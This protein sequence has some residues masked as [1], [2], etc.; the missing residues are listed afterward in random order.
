MWFFVTGT[1]LLNPF[2]KF[3]IERPLDRPLGFSFGTMPNPAAPN[4]SQLDQ[5]QLEKAHRKHLLKEKTIIVATFKPEVGAKV[6]Q[7]SWYPIS[8]LQA[9]LSY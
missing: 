3:D 7:V 2:S 6:V 4:V 1:F 8:R 5:A 9:V